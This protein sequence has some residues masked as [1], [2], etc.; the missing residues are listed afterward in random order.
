MTDALSENTVVVDGVD[1]EMT[2]AELQTVV[3]VG[4]PL[5]QYAVTALA[6]TAPDET[7][8]VTD[9]AVADQTAGRQATRQQTDSHAEMS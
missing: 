4:G 1:T 9:P 6:M 8:A 5:A 7:S 3:E 2:R